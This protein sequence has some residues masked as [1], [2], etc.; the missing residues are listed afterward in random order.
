MFG[1][2]LAGQLEWP[3]LKPI[4]PIMSDILQSG[5]KF[6][7]LKQPS[8]AKERVLGDRFFSHSGSALN[9]AILGQG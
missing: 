3:H 1:C 5:Y 6:V 7:L 9:G 2:I 8:T 4:I